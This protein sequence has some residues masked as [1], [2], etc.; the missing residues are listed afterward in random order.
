M[1][2]FFNK[3]NLDHSIFFQTENNFYLFTIASIVFFIFGY[4]DD[5]Y[6][7][8]SNLKLILLIFFVIFFIFLDNNLIINS[9]NLS[10][11][12]RLIH[13]GKYQFIFTLFC[14]VAFINAFNLFDGINCQIGIYI[15]FILSVVFFYNNNLLIIVSLFFSLLI[16]LILNLKNK[17]FLGN[18]G[19]YFLGF[20]ISFIIIK[21][22]NNSNF[23]TSDKILLIMALPGIDMIRLFVLR[24][25]KKVN[26]FSPDRNHFHHMLIDNLNYKMTILILTIVFVSPYMLSFFLTSYVSLLIFLILY[27][28]IIKLLKIKKQFT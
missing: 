8:G 27:Y 17:I 23:V 22:Y 9:L 14:F 20:I 15:F 16:F 12:D 11:T 2:I 3:E 25:K 28:G 4:I 6:N 26:P 21:T 19:S 13:L 7:L 5:K 24:I 1:I 10:F 18:A